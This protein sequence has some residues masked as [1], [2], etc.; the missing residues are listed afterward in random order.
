VKNSIAIPLVALVFAAGCSASSS[1]PVNTS[2]PSANRT[3]TKAAVTQAATGRAK[4]LYIGSFTHPSALYAVSAL[5]NGTVTPV[6]TITT[7]VDNFTQTESVVYDRVRNWVWMSTCPAL[8][9]AESPVLAFPATANGSTTPVATIGGAN[10]GIGNCIAGIALN[11]TQQ[12]YVSNFV[13]K[14]SP[15]GDIPIFGKNQRGNVAPRRLIYGT[16]P[17]IR[18]PFGITIA[19]R[20]R[21]YVTNSCY[22]Y[23]RC[24]GTGI[25]GY[26]S[27]ANG[28]VAPVASIPSTTKTQVDVPQGIAFDGSG[29]MYVT[30][31]ANRIEVFAG[32][33]NGDV[34][35]IRVIQS[36]DLC[37]PTEIA[38][39]HAGYI[40]VGNQCDTPNWPVLV[41][42]P[43]AT[44]T[45]TPVQ[46][47]AIK[48]SDSVIA[49]GV[50]LQY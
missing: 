6:R 47:I 28:Q 13:T 15:G 48:T 49:S 24:P 9:G 16:K 10:T 26:A 5:A 44:G 4:T 31:K 46:K 17:N 41:F 8:P 11:S 14:T 42:S 37:N 23:N 29:N 34:A 19:P 25:T 38:I 1:L 43:N 30:D 3:L 18:S 21:L 12:L 20:G 39:D 40:Y 27:N 35:P 50:A 32:N 22:F 7:T 45:V 2:A 33:A 36:K